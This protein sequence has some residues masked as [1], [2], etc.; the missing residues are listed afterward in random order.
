MK[1]SCDAR[2]AIED[3][4]NALQT[5]VLLVGLLELGLGRTL[6]EGDVANL[7]QAVN[8]AANAAG[9][10]QKWAHGA[11]RGEQHDPQS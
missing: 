3:L 2:E 5:I 7:R 1:R 8:R 11:T 4:S 10:L 9:K 6:W